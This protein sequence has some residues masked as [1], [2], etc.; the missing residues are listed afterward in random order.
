MLVVQVMLMTD[1]LEI[2]RLCAEAMGCAVHATDGLGLEHVYIDHPVPGRDG[3]TF[4]TTLYD[5][6]H[7][8]VQAMALVKKFQLEIGWHTNG[9]ASVNFPTDNL[10][11]QWIDGDTL[12]RAIVE[13]V[14]KMQ[15][16]ARKG[17]QDAETRPQPR[18]MQPQEWKKFYGPDS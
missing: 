3:K 10:E 15:Q 9:H 8:D 4:G 11:Q 16:R 12:N 5:P 2:T 7:D 14:A 18:W 6:L 17:I 1:D 13:C